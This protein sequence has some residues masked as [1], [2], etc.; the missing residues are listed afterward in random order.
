MVE[1]VTSQDEFEQNHLLLLAIARAEKADCLVSLYSATESS[2]T[3]QYMLEAVRLHA[4]AQD[5][6]QALAT[7][8]LI[9]ETG[10]FTVK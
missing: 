9:F 4:M 10:L 6:F 5:V 8:T 7:S 1:G 3:G 2:M